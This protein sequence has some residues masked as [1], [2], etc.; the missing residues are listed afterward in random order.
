MSTRTPKHIFLSVIRALFLR[1]LEMRFSV[2]RTGLFWTFF[3]PFLQILLFVWI[4]Y[5]IKSMGG[6][7][8][9]FNYTVFIA[10]G[11]IPFNMFRAI[12]SSSSG[13]FIAN[14]GLFAYRQI[15]PIDTIIARALV[16]L[17][18]TAII[19]VMFLFI[20]LMLGVEDFLP[21]NTA[22]SLLALLWLW[23][24]STSIGILVAI[25]NVFFISV[26]KLVSISTFA[27]LIFSAVFFP[28]ISLSPSGQEIL[29]YNPLTHFMEMIHGYYVIGL[30]DRFVDYRYM[31]LWTLAPLFVGIWLYSLLA[32]RIVSL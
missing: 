8:F 26:G 32:K 11:F 29:L 5:I 7:H 16:E 18:L 25:G 6:G 31:L 3:E 10:S 23:V 21:K 24:F 2:G 28:I 1:E 13:A 20:S 19:I 15:K 4:H 14:K 17:F 9:S 12:L 30:D 27:L 22:A